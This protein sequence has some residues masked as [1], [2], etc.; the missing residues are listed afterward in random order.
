MPGNYWK[1]T[2]TSNFS[3]NN[4]QMNST[5]RGA[6]RLIF[7]FHLLAEW[8]KPARQGSDPWAQGAQDV[9]DRTCRIFQAKFSRDKLSDMVIYDLPKWP[10]RA[11]VV[12]RWR[13]VG[14][15]WN[16]LNPASLPTGACQMGP[17]IGE[18]FGPC[19]ITGSISPRNTAYIMLKTLEQSDVHTGILPIQTNVSR[20]LRT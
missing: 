18:R 6:I 20:L 10:R 8:N 4:L 12:A 11:P 13:L 1:I 5:Q 3:F 7:H 16:C 17:S 9:F 19:L 14:I 2:I 15:D